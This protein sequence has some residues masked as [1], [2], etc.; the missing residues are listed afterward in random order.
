MNNPWPKKP[1]IFYICVPLKGAN[2]QAIAEFCVTAR[3]RKNW[4]WESIAR[5]L[6]LINNRGAAKG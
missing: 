1:G 2:D 6:A 5:D 3:G 4:L